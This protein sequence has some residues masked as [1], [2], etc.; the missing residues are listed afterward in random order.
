MIDEELFKRRLAFIHDQLKDRDLRKLC[1]YCEKPLRF[2]V[3]GKCIDQ[4]H[5]STGT[6]DY[7]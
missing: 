7:F 5:A 2:T 3:H 6:T 1:S 4:F